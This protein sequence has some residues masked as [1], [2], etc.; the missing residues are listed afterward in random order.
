MNYVS[1]LLLSFA[2]GIMVVVQGGLN[3]K[4]G[5]LLNNPLLGTSA[6]LTM[7]A[8]FTLVAVFVS[9]K[10]FPSIQ[11]IKAIPFYL[12]FTGAAFSFIAVSLFY[13]LIPKLGISTAV[14][15]GLCGQIAFSMIAAHFGWFGLPVEPISF[16]KILG[17]LMLI[18]GVFLSKY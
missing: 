7:S 9:V 18:G 1:M 10:E 4:L 5:V 3:A 14:T 13:Y 17:V 15:F 16:K 11:Q 8:C 2:V 6:A 12:W